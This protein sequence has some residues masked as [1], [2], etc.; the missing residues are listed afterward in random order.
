[1]DLPKVNLT[2]PFGPYVNNM[3]ITL[4]LKGKPV[5]VPSGQAKKYKKA[6]EKICN[7]RDDLKPFAGE[8]RVEM[9]FYRPRRV[10][11]LDGMFKAVI[12]A[13]KGF[14]FE[15]DKQIVEIHAQ[16]FDDKWKPRVEVEIS[17]IRAVQELFP[18]QE[19]ELIY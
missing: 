12:D 3:Y 9:K 2:L 4:M 16:R 11:D 13:L 17:E 7:A 8:L 1:M 19:P 18:D 5:R 10:G 14:A 6:V 15:D